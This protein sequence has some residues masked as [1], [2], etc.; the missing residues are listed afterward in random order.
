VKDKEKAKQLQE[1]EAEKA[2]DLAA[3]K[4]AQT[5]AKTKQ[6]ELQQKR[7][8][9]WKARDERVKRK[10]DEWLKKV[11]AVKH[12]MERVAK[13]QWER[14]QETIKTLHAERQPIFAA[15]L[16][17]CEERK[18]AQ[19]AEEEALSKYVE[20]REIPKKEKTKGKNSAKAKA[21]AAAPKKDGEAAPAKGGGSIDSV[22]AKMRL[23]MEMQLRF[24][25]MEKKRQ[26]RIAKLSQKRIDDENSHM[27]DYR[28]DHRSKESAINQAAAERHLVLAQKLD[29]QRSAAERKKIEQDRLN[30]TRAENIAAKMQARLTA[31]AAS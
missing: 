10:N 5:K 4:D 19:V 12:E 31:I 1:A 18:L 11:M 16:Q 9:L 15:Q 25:K 6:E 8:S 23:Q 21:A 28:E 14:N 17:R 3:K 27:K 2:K 24:E 13:M 26:E 22:E 29:D 20:K 7:R 30:K